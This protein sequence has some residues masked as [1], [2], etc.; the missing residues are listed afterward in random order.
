MGKRWNCLGWKRLGGDSCVKGKNKED[1]AGLLSVESGDRT[2]GTN[3]IQEVLSDP[4]EILFSLRV[5]EHLNKLP[6]QVVEFL[7]MEKYKSCLNVALGQL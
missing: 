4:E 5:A 2:I 6:I 3:E 7:P 1:G